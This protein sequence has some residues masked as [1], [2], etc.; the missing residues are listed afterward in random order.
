[1]ATCSPAARVREVR[2]RRGTARA[3]ARTL[4]DRRRDEGTE[5]WPDLLGELAR[6][7]RP[8][9]ARVDVDHGHVK[10]EREEVQLERLQTLHDSP[11][12]V[13]HR[14]RTTGGHDERDTNDAGAEDKL[15]TSE[16]GQAPLPVQYCDSASKLAMAFHPAHAPPA[17]ELGSW[18][19]DCAGHL[20]QETI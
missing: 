15:K 6:R 2:R 20:N 12:L 5:E 10:V 3:V 17:P 13:L 1:M 11:A 18:R 9:A 7:A 19:L 8:A 16:G 14:S 4:R